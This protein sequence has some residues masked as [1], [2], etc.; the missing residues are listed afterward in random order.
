MSERFLRDLEL[1]PIQVV[2]FDYV[3]RSI[4]PPLRSGID[5]KSIRSSLTASRTLTEDGQWAAFPVTPRND[6]REEQAVFEGL[7]PVFTA[8]IE[9]ARKTAERSPTVHL[10]KNPTKNNS[11]RPDAYLLMEDK[12]SVQSQSGDSQDSWDDIAV[13]LEFKKDK[14]RSERINNDQK[15]IWSL[16]HIM[17]ND[18]CRRSTFGVT[19]EDTEVRLWFTCRSVTV[20]AEAFDFVTDPDELI[21]L[22]CAL[23]FAD[24]EELGWD[25]TIQRVLV[26]GETRYD[27]TFQEKEE[28]PAVYRTI[29]IISD[30]GADAMM[31]K[32]TRVFKAYLKSRQGKAVSAPVEHVVIKD[33]WRDPDR[34]REDQILQQVLEDV[35]TTQGADAAEDARKYFLTVLRGEDI[36]INGRT[37]DTLCL[38]HGETVPDGCPW[39]EV[40]LDRNSSRRPHVS[41][42]GDM[43]DSPFRG[44]TPAPGSG[45]I[46]NKQ[47]F[48]L[49]FDEVCQPIF[50]FKSLHDV[51]KTLLH[52]VAG[53]KYMHTAG[54]VHRD[55]SVGNVLR[56]GDQGLIT[57]L[58]YAKPEGSL[59]AVVRRRERVSEVQPLPWGKN[60][61]LALALK[62][63][64]CPIRP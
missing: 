62:L 6:G 14:S 28:S 24:E 55:I 18:P 3:L 25:P 16:H 9:E 35:R 13:S 54:W 2:P 29:A 19:I 57:D 39:R 15:L 63:A 23:A 40:L 17:H 27:I 26:E 20:V 46:Q 32:G 64:L 56:H 58:E 33:S 1:V 30:F 11:S 10:V 45:M 4:L 8:I 21:H 59:K 41:S 38:L 60:I 36:S 43:P 22:V 12:K 34:E 61:P 52:A 51:L 7:Q 37:D 49:V 42:V 50:E 44:V 53:L 47:H 48:R 5:I 31:G